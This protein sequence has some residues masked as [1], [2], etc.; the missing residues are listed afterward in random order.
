MVQQPGSGAPRAV[1]PKPVGA[2]LPVRDEAGSFS[3]AYIAELQ[4][5]GDQAGMGAEGQPGDGACAAA[6]APEAAASFSIRLGSG[7]Q[8]MC[9]GEQSAQGSMRLGEAADTHNP[10]AGVANP[11]LERAHTMDAF[12]HSPL[13]SGFIIGEPA[14]RSGS[15]CCKVAVTAERT[16]SGVP[17][18]RP[19]A[20]AGMP[21]AGQAERRLPA[22]PLC[23]LA[24]S[25]CRSLK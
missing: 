16:T 25:A 1:T 14:S 13:P 4:A 22:P 19:L 20:G 5:G 21:M 17:G 6:A 2:S 23:M 15:G 18:E 10:F 11:F 9:S 24:Y 7:G 3:S 8:W 12:S